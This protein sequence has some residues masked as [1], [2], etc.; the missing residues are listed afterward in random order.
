MCG[1][2]QFACKARVFD[3]YFIEVHRF[4]EEAR[5]MGQTRFD[6][7]RRTLIKSSLVGSALASMPC[8]SATESSSTG[9]VVETTSGKVRGVVINGVHVFR[10]LPY[11]ASTAGPN[12]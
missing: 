4:D 7:G 12:R 10:G 1:Q 3:S 2:G 9:P 8:F 11:G 5:I 6:L